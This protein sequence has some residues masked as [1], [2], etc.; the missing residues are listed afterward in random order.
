MNEIAILSGK[1]G[2][3]KT[4]LTASLAS[5]SGVSVL[6]DCDVDASDL[7]LVLEATATEQHAF[8]SGA[9]AVLD[10]QTCNGCGICASLCRYGAIEKGERTMRVDAQSCE[11]CGVCVR[12]CPRS[13]LRLRERDCGEWMI[14]QTRC[15]PMVHARLRPGSEN[16][17]KL[18]SLVRQ[19]AKKLARESAANWLWVDGPPGIGCP[20]IASITGARAV[21]AVSEPSLSAGHD[22]ERLLELTRHFSIPSFLVMNRAELCPELTQKIEEQSRK[23]GAV[24]LGRIPSDPAVTEAQFARKSVVEL[25]DSPASQAIRSLWERL[26]EAL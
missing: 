15:G 13:A 7:H 4:S 1:G 2:T 14:S 3:G 23:S 8:V 20:A 17:G 11:G 6:A 5:L 12:F 22:V 26:Q 21:I 10:P 19:Q 24:L 25:G 16:S 18:V 9:F